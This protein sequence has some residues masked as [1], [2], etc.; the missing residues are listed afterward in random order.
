[1]R[2]PSGAMTNPTEG[3]KQRTFVFPQFLGRESEMEVSAGWSPGVSLYGVQTT[4]FSL[5]P[6]VCPSVHVGGCLL[7]VSPRCPCVS[8]SSL[9][10]LTNTPIRPD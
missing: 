2:V 8:V 7:P 5:C 6:M 9:P 1:M 10:F 4:T 3:P